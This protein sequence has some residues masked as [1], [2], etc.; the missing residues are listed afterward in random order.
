MRRRL[1][2]EAGIALVLTLLIMLVLAITLTSL[3]FY[4][5]ANSRTSQYAKAKQVASTIADAGLNNAL[6]II[7]DPDNQKF[8]LKSNLLPAEMP[9]SSCTAPATGCSFY[10]GGK[11]VWWGSLDFTTMVWTIGA[12]GIVANPTGPSALPVTRT[13]S[14]L[15][16]I[17]QPPPLTNT[18]GVWNSLFSGATGSSSCDT[19]LANQGA[20]LAPVE[21]EGNLC[22]QNQASVDNQLFVGGW[23]YSQQPQ[24]GVGSSSAPV[25]NVYIGNGCQYRSIGTFYNPCV[26]D[27]TKV[28]G[29][30][31][32]TNV[33]ATSLVTSGPPQSAFNGLSAPPVDW[34][35]WYQNA[36]P[37][38]WHPCWDPTTSQYAPA[39]QGPVPTFD[40]MSWNATDQE[41]E[42]D[43]FNSPAGGD[44]PGGAFNL[45]PP[46]SYTCEVPSGGKLDWNAATSTLTVKG[47]IFIDGSAYING[48]AATYTGQGV[49][50][51]SG[52][53][54]IKNASLCATNPPVGGNCNAASWNPNK[55]LLIFAT[56]YT[57]TQIDVPSPEGISVKNSSFQGGLYAD[58]AIQLDTTSQVQG[59]IVT[60]S[61]FTIG[62]KY[63]SSFPSITIA[64]F[65]LPGTQPAYYAGPP[66]SFTG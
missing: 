18:E 13:L 66:G 9:D 6:A 60:P 59:P 55:D 24:T 8:L 15:V 29:V 41:Y 26:V 51:L 35:D 5:S 50:M 61:S 52:T 40:V 31:A 56:H 34:T 10:E 33:F 43:G 38:P 27:G 30:K 28:K 42:P 37:G 48:V 46:T 45:T 62:N 16:Q 14:A 63:A 23:L 11:V 65:G 64:P 25:A 47:A 22:L 54:D 49:I 20:I 21:V 36:A 2:D 53:L 4:A 3:I 39:S 7:E 57:G 19:T 58:Y 12:K 32:S 44:A 17:V 1:A